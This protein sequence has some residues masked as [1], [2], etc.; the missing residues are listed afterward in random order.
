MTADDDAT[1]ERPWA[2]LSGTLG[3]CRLVKRLGSGGHGTAFLAEMV[4]DRPYAPAGS[5]VVVKVLHPELAADPRAQERFQREAATG[6]AISHPSV[7]RTHEASVETVGGAPCW[8]LVLE[9]VEG[10]SLREIVTELAPL[11]EPLLRDIAL[12][13]ARALEA[14]HA[15]G[16]LHRDVKPANVMLTRDHQLKLLDLSVARIVDQ[17]GSLT[18]SQAFIG[19]ALHAAPE[20]FEGSPLGPATDLYA[21][22]ATLYEAAT[23][24]QPFAADDLRG[25]AWRH[26]EVIPPRVATLNPRLTPFLEEILAT[27]LAKAPAARFPSAA[28]LAEILDEGEA[29]SWWRLREAELRLHGSRR[30]TRRPRAPRLTRL[31]GRTRELAELETAWQEARAGRGSLVLLEGEAGVGKTRLLDEMLQ[32]IEESGADVAVP[33]AANAPGAAGAAASVLGEALVEHFSDAHLETSLA[34]AMPASPTLVPAFAA[35]LRGL[36][37]P[38]GTASMSG[39]AVHALLCQVTRSLAAER[40]VVWVVED[41]HFATAETLAHVLSLARVAPA[42]RILIL[43]SA[44]PGVEGLGEG[45]LAR[46]PGARRVIVPRLSPDETETLL[47]ASLDSDTL[48]QRLRDVVVR[49]SDGNPFFTLELARTLRER[50]PHAPPVGASTTRRL[51][52]M[53]LPSSVKGLVLSLVADCSDEDRALLDAAAVAGFSFDADLLARVL[54]RRRLAVLQSLAALERRRGLVRATGSGFAFDHHLL[55]EVLYESLAP[56]LRGE[57]HAQL[58]LAHAAR[59]GVD[60]DR[61]GDVPGEDAVFLATHA[62]QG[63]DPRVG[64]A[65]ALPA[66]AHLRSL[67]QHEAVADLAQLALERI[68]EDDAALRCDLLVQRA[69]ALGQAGA[70]EES[71]AACEQ[72]CS[73]ADAGADPV[74]RAR[75]RCE[76]AAVLAHRGELSRAS[77]LAE[78]ALALA[79]QAGDR[80]GAARA[81]GQVG[82]ARYHAGDY[83][84]A[85]AAFEEQRAL[86]ASIGDPLRAA[87]ARANIGLSAAAMGRDEEAQRHVEDYRAVSEREGHLEGVGRACANLG[88][89]FANRGEAERALREYERFLALSRQCA[90]RSDEAIAVGNIGAAC[91]LAGQWGRAHEHAVRHLTLAREVGD[92]SGEAYALDNLGGLACAEGRLEE[93]E[94]HLQAALTLTRERRLRGIEAHVLLDLGDVARSKG[95]AP[96]ARAWYQQA[97]E[98]RREI[99]M[100]DGI[101]ETLVALARL[102]ADAGDDAAAVELAREALGEGAPHAGGRVLAAALLAR[103]GERSPGSVVIPESQPPHVRAEAHLHLHVAGRGADHLSEA[104]RILEACSSHLA[105]SRLDAFWTRNPLAR[106]VRDEPA[107]S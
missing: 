57:Y 43:A 27:L 12:Q 51:A 26:L 69:F 22:G 21:L 24:V 94:A 13:L 16:I 96:A 84:A 45:R 75:A 18:G 49:R 3:P 56:A 99:R 104:R 91:R 101:P 52:G 35:L 74:R 54:E 47:T 90:N 87:H 63:G 85:R 8:F 102:C 37:P 11:A 93:A 83:E 95:D 25:I 86:Y 76:L 72:A 4:A 19:S 80:V 39:E 68:S 1:V 33:C 77:G 107:Q 6:L 20:Q 29:S 17:T 82:V 71:H 55:Q 73:A 88:M 23:G 106:A 60:L 97:L 103:L 38:A 31:V 67:Y 58:A 7:V 14:V 70:A 65:V 10:R 32:R 61:L 42:E 92:A 79:Q 46:V 98:L 5:R 44:R 78:E 28:R 81:L 53:E 62:L 105:G 9:H 66:M 36:P 59:R 30:S 15:A 34:R 48:A 41:L 2:R 64:L 89:I 40:P 100:A 50:G